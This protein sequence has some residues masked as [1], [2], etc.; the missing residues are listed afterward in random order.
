MNR[1][2]R[3]A[4]K[5]NCRFASIIF[6][7]SKLGYFKLLFEISIS[8]HIYINIDETRRQKLSVKSFRK[9]L[10]VCHDTVM[11]TLKLLVGFGHCPCV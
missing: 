3:D 9:L 1:R 11:I 10:I 6:F 7:G 4:Y 5:K 2:Q 8:L